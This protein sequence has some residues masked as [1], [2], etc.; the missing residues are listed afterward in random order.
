M[1]C[2]S[3]LRQT[4]P[5]LFFLLRSTRR[6]TSSHLILRLVLDLVAR[7]FLPVSLYSSRC[8]TPLCR[9]DRSSSCFSMF[10]LRL[11]EL[12]CVQSCG[13]PCRPWRLPVPLLSGMQ[14]LFKRCLDF[15]LKSA[16]SGQCAQRLARA[17]GILGVRIKIFKIFCVQSCFFPLGVLMSGFFQ[18]RL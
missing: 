4:T 3:P 10:L 16:R 5:L 6:S 14:L 17:C 11:A 2:P 18:R 15:F 7:L 9:C 1:W 12:F 8:Q 13:A